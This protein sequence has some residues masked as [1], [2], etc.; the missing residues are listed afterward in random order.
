MI[1][2]IVYSLLILGFYNQHMNR[3]PEDKD[4]RDAF[5]QCEKIPFNTGRKNCFKKIKK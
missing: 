3:L 2:A 1:Y 4:K 5:L